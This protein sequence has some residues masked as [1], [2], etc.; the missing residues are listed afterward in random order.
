M[1]MTKMER[2]TEYTKSLQVLCITLWIIA[3]TV[4]IMMSFMLINYKFITVVCLFS[5]I[6]C[7]KL[8]YKT[9]RKMIV[10]SSLTNFVLDMRS[11]YTHLPSNNDISRYYSSN[12]SLIFFTTSVL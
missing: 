5:L 2:T 1:N 7:F 6:S 9:V 12:I 3:N 8:S 10:Q 11:N 4:I